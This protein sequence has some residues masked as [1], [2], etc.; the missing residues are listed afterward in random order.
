VIY[1]YNQGSARVWWETIKDSL[2]RFKNLKIIHLQDDTVQNLTKM[3]QRKMQIQCT[4][5]DGD[6]WISDSE[7]SVEITLAN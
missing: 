7:V 1:T 6:I 4:I 3:A 5:E 2:Q